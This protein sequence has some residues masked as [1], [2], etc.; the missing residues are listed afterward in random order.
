RTSSWAKVY[1]VR[2]W[3]WSAS[4]PSRAWSTAAWARVHPSPVPLNL[5]G[6]NRAL[7]GLGSYI[8]NAQGGCNDCH[9]WPSYKAGGDPFLGQQPKEVNTDGYM[10]GGRFF[11]AAPYPVAL[12]GCVI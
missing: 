12:E 3:L 8:V 2:I 10:A 7:V 9:T 11:F 1:R 6:K 4:S 5:Q